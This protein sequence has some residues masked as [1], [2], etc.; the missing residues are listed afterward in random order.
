M[1]KYL[2]TS[3][4]FLAAVAIAAAFLSTARASD[5]ID[6]PQ[7]ANDHASDINDMYFFLDPNDNSQ[8][9]LVMTI[10]PFLISSEIIGQ[11]IFDH[12][13]RYRFE[14]ENTGD[15]QTDAFLDVRFTR[16]VGR[17]TGPQTATV[18]LPNGQTFTA[19]T[20]VPSQGAD[21][22]NTQPP[23]L[24]VTTD[25]ASG[26]SIFAGVSD[27]PFFLDNTAANRFVLSSVANPGNPNRAIFANRAGF[28]AKDGSD[29][30][31]DNQGPAPRQGSNAGQNQG[32]GRDTYAGFSTLTI[33][34]RAP[35]A[36]LRGAP[37]KANLQGNL[38][39]LNGVTQR[40]RFQIVQTHGQVVASGP[41]V[42]VDR[43]GVP[44]VNNGLIPPSRKDEY[45]GSTPADDASGRFRADL[46]TSI[47]NFGTNAANRDMLLGMIQV[48]GDL[49]RMD[50]RVPNTGPGGG[51]NTNGGPANMGGRRLQDDVADATFTLLNNGAPLGDFVD[52]NDFIFG[53]LF[54]FVAPQVMPNPNGLNSKD[55]RLRL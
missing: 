10:N 53:N 29:P 50:L 47:N 51:N 28:N 5:H 31:A 36:L 17:E 25:S 48:N 16:S 9:V 39:G 54:P 22:S 41:F 23:P 18:T 8:V 1:K 49:V 46:I 20:N 38:L 34:V 27:D 3:F 14:I 4:L 13:I 21:S 40:Q 45:N 24:T 2:S 44:L 33:A 12:N 6:G 11:A 19:F 26:V 52:R 37:N 15:A 42:T 55:T 43:E 32:A 35:A 7:L 30:N